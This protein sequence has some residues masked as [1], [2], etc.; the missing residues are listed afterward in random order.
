MEDIVEQL[1]MIRPTG[2][3][4]CTTAAV[5]VKCLSM[6]FPPTSLV[7]LARLF[8]RDGAAFFGKC[9][10]HAFSRDAWLWLLRG[11]RN[12]EAPRKQDTSPI[13][14]SGLF[15]ADWYL[16]NNPD[17]RQ[18]G[19]NPAA[20][21][22]LHGREPLRN[23]GPDFVGDEYIALNT[24]IR[25][26]E[27]NPLV[28]FERHGRKENRLTSFLQIRPASYPN[29]AIETE[30]EFPAAPRRHRRFAVFAAHSGASRIPETTLHYL[31]GLKEVVDDIVFVTSNPVLPDEIGKL[32]GLVRFAAFHDHGGYDFFSY[33]LG[34]EKAKEFGLTAPG[35]NDEFVLANDS[36]YAP[37]FPF[38]E[39]F[40]KM[41]GRTCD[42]WGM[43]ANKSFVGKEH[44]QSYF[45]VFRR[46]V[47]DDGS[48]D[49]FLEGVEPVSNRWEVILRYEAGITNALASAGHEWDTLV[50][51]PFAEETGTTPTK[52]PIA[53]MSGYGMPLVKI[54]AMKGDMADNREEVLD[55][56]RARNPGLA[57]A[58]P[59]APP[60]PDHGLLRRL[61][62]EH[63]ASFPLKVEA[64][65]RER[66]GRGLTVRALFLVA[67]PSMFPARARL[68]AMLRDPAFD[69]RIFV[70][71]DLRC[72]DR[73]SESARRSCRKELGADYPDGRFLE[74]QPDAFGVWP[75]VIGEFGADIV[76]YPSPY[77]LS[78]FRFNPH[79]AVGRGFLPIHVGG[80]SSTSLDGSEVF[81]LQNFAYFWKVFV[82]GGETA[83]EYAEHS[84]LR[85]ANAVAVN[86][87]HA[88]GTA[89]ES[90][91]K[92]LGI[93]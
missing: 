22:L 89:L 34:W 79:W 5:L 61:R 20:H 38:Q 73:D 18:A 55:F 74:A 56:I 28:H 15:D 53:T 35:A 10:R 44:I 48:L 47:L 91:R 86:P 21:Y 29:G 27:I 2:A 75:D 23:P 16:R 93:T 68:D 42:F 41:A 19:G 25:I 65:R 60:P 52:M 57:A 37:V 8:R 7:T 88:A 39:C 43:T 40:K 71:P 54:S 26:I 82:E 63:P 13:L 67:S 87:P 49:R 83:R 92:A 90:I 58:I 9:I 32:E 45:F 80:D 1:Y 69:A 85:G 64:I 14:A 76:C 33:R 70:I 72:R 84:L 50:P 17:V 3:S 36:C 78:C 30:R 51:R 12:A 66:V 31:R 46:P 59:P 6:T 81:G 4:V 11:G 77:D 24:D 62:E